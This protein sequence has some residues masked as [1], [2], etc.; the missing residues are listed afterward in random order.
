M[1][2]C[3]E[4]GMPRAAATVAAAAH[5]RY[6]IIS[7]LG[8]DKGRLQ[9]VEIGD[10]EARFAQ[11]GLVW[12]AEVGHCCCWEL[13][14][15]VPGIH[16][17]PVLCPLTGITMVDRFVDVGDALCLRFV[18]ARL[19][20]TWRCKGLATITAR[21]GASLPPHATDPRQRW[22]SGHH[23]ISACHTEPEKYEHNQLD[24]GRTNT[25]LPLLALPRRWTVAPQKTT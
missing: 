24:S 2:R 1:T 25:I 17:R 4:R 5:L 11:A 23:M 16:G 21:G 13:V 20:G 9:F 18:A 15:W 6:K 14:A 12:A 22:S 8:R 19:P 10:A 7:L 3:C